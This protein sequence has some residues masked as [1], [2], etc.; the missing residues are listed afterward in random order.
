MQALTLLL[1][2]MYLLTAILSGISVG[3]GVETHMTYYR[4]QVQVN[5]NYTITEV[6][7]SNLSLRYSKA[8]TP[9]M[10][11]SNKQ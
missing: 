8:L 11:V 9:C 10:I 2:L 7:S 3:A 6:K 4:G 5:A 1:W